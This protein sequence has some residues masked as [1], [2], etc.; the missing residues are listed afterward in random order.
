MPCRAKHRHLALIEGAGHFPWL[1]APDTYWPTIND[2]VMSHGVEGGRQTD[3][4]I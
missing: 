3:Q 2:F 4:E 1:D